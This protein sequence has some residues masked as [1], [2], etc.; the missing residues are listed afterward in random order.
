MVHVV[1]YDP[2]WPARYARAR[3]ELL[4]LADGRLTEFEHVG[5]TSVPGLAAKPVIDMAAVAPG[6][7]GFPHD[8]FLPL[9]YTYQDF[10]ASR[11]LLFV[12]RDGTTRTHH[13]HVYP[14]DGWDHNPQRLLASHLRK[15]PDAARRYSALKRQIIAD[16]IKG[17]DYTYAKSELI[18]ELLDAARA[19]RGL[20]PVP[21]WES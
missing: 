21:A 13:L 8:L 17:E 4:G 5:S 19:E 20:P 10:G 2:A 15:H 3:D 12:K 14:A 7:D 18:Q 9:G 11:H 16:G 6:L 1:A